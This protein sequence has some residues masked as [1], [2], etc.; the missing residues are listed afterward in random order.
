MLDIDFRL[1]LSCVS[2]GLVIANGGSGKEQF[3][4]HPLHYNVGNCLPK[5]GHLIFLKETTAHFV[6]KFCHI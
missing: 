2:A 3:A 4:R 1:L 5:L 6:I